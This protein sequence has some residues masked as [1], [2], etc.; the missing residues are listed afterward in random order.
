MTRGALLIAIVVAAFGWPGRGAAQT[1]EITTEYLM[2]YF[3]PLARYRSA[4]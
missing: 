2:T 3:A 4:P 1:S